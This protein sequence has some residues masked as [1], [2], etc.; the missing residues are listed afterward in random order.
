MQQLK[1]RVSQR[2]VSK[3]NNQRSRKS[4]NQISKANPQKKVKSS[5]H[6]RLYVKRYLGQRSMSKDENIKVKILKY[7][8]AYSIDTL[9]Y[10]KRSL[11]KAL[12]KIVIYAGA[13]DI[14]NNNNYLNNVIKVVKLVKVTCKDTKLSFSLVICCSTIKEISD[15]IKTTNSHLENYC[16]QQNSGFIDNA[17]IKKSDFN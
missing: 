13:N 12:V 17:N 8:G 7:P 6:R 11:W 14:S 3:S 15:T 10:I 4:N 9:G 1:R 2:T 5:N 16:K